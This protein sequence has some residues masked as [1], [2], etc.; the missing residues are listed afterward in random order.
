[1]RWQRMPTR[2]GIAVRT[3]ACGTRLI[4]CGVNAAGSIE[5]GRQ[6]GGNLHGG[7]RGRWTLSP[8][9]Q[10]CA[11]VKPCRFSPKGPSPPA[12]RRSMP[13]GKSRAK[14]SLRWA[15]ARCGPPQRANRYS[16][17]IGSSRKSR[18][19]RRRAGDEQVAAGERVR[20]HCKQMR[21][22][23]ERADAAGCPDVEPGRNGADRCP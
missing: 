2:L 17:T 16:T 20:R 10:R 14:G 1:M 3:L 4:D 15:R 5:A 11:A 22:G 9:T 13:A 19:V 12:W 6:A 21:R 23:A 18:T 8:P 7:A